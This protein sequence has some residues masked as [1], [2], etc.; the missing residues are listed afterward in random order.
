MVRFENSACAFDDPAR[1]NV[2]L[3][4]RDEHSSDTQTGRNFEAAL[5]H[6]MTDALLAKLRQY[7]VANVTTLLQQLS[8]EAVAH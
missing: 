5:H 8:V 7:G 1:G 2:R 3:V 4:A 6:P